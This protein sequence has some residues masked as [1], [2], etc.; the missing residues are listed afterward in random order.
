MITQQAVK[1]IFKQLSVS[2]QNRLLDEL[3]L[4]QEL[5]GKV[6]DEANEEIVH[7]RKKKPCPHCSSDKT[8]KRG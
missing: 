8:H 2:N 1:D 7:H 4:E 5:Q 6:L 3:L